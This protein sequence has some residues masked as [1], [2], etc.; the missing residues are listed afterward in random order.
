[1]DLQNRIYNTNKLRYYYLLIYFYSIFIFIL[2]INTIIYSNKIPN[3]LLQI[4]ILI[5]FIIA[6]LNFII[7]KN[8][9]T[10]KEGLTKKKKW[11]PF[12]KIKNPFAKIKAIFGGGQKNS[13]CFLLYREYAEVQKQIDQIDEEYTNLLEDIKVYFSGIDMKYLNLEKEV[14]TMLTHLA[15]NLTNIVETDNPWNTQYVTTLT[16]INNIS[17][18]LSQIEKNT[19]P[20]NYEKSQLFIPVT[21]M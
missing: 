7:Y 1:M 21:N 8:K 19:N 5:I 2:G 13:Q 15:S 17:N 11:N 18:G 20:K 6:F 12:A 16:G 3:N 4:T 14:N 9:K 10:I